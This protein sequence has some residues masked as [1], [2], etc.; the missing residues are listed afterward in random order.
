MAV[1]SVR[2]QAPIY[3]E[4]INLSSQFLYKLISEE[5]IHLGLFNTM[6][7]INILIVFVRLQTAQIPL[8]S[9]A[10]ITW[11][12]FNKWGIVQWIRIYRKI[13]VNSGMCFFY[14]YSEHDDSRRELKM[15]KRR[16]SFVAAWCLEP[17][18]ITAFFY[19]IQNVQHIPWH[20]TFG[21]F[22]P[23]SV[24]QNTRTSWMACIHHFRDRVS[25]YKC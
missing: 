13:N 11:H 12:C 8:L 3:R 20:T 10:S 9:N 14:V 6:L 23:A 21:V 15:I 24:V 16:V 19:K 2:S 18:L 5:H 1:L 4:S 17:P 7:R 22:N 25:Q